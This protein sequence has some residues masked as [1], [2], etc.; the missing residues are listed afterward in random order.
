MQAMIKPGQQGYRM[1]YSKRDEEYL[2]KQG[3]VKFNPAPVS[4]E[5]RPTLTLPK[6]GRPKA[7]K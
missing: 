3:W 6:R 5:R 7:D 4:S 2:V 1:A